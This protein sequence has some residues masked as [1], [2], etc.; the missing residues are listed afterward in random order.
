M[1]AGVAAGD[2]ELTTSSAPTAANLYNRGTGMRLAAVLTNDMLYLT[3]TDDHIASLADLA[4]RPVL[5]PQGGRIV[6]AH[7]ISAA[8]RNRD[9]AF[10]QAE[11]ARL[12]ARP[13]AER[14]ASCGLR[15][16]A[17]RFGGSAR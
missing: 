4:G 11:V 14:P 15:A 3:A 17:G 12:M 7:P 2:I 5:V 8:P 6:D 1:R 13:I 9:A 16:S 10:I